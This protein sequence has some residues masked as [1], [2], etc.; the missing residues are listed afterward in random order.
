MRWFC[1]PGLHLNTTRS[2]CGTVTVRG[3]WELQQEFWVASAQCSIFV[4]SFWSSRWGGGGGIGEME[5]NQ[6]RIRASGRVFLPNFSYLMTPFYTQDLS[7]VLIVY[8]KLP[9]SQRFFGWLKVLAPLGTTIFWKRTPF[10][11]Q[12]LRTPNKSN[13]TV[14][15]ILNDRLWVLWILWFL[16]FYKGSTWKHRVVGFSTDL[17]KVPPVGQPSVHV[18]P[19]D[20]PNFFFLH[21]NLQL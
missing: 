4:R 10:P 12:R 13:F 5:V 21:V 1:A 2:A 16:D 3:L 17:L 18:F 6:E 9:V 8:T 20:L 15:E 14:E 7:L 19:L 11:F